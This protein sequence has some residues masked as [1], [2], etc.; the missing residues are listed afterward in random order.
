MSIDI[1][2]SNG[3]LRRLDGA[4]I[5]SLRGQLR[6]ALLAAGDAGYD[7]ARRI[8][9]AMIDK[10]PALVARCS[11]DADVMRVVRF[12]A[13]NELLLSVKGGGHN[14]AGSAVCEGG[15]M[16]D[17]S[18]MKGVRIDA[19]RRVAHA[20]SGLLWQELD[21]E[22]QAFGLATTGGVVGET[23]IAGLTIG[24]GVGWL[25][26]KHGMS[27]D[28]L[29][30]ADVVTADGRRLTA[31]RSQH[32]DLFWALRGGGGNFGVVTSFEFALHEVG[33]VLGGLVV[34]PREAAADVIRFHRDFMQ[35]APD[36]L[37]SYVGLLTTP[38]GA[39]VVAL[40]CCY[41]GDLAAGERAVAPMRSFGRPLVDDLKV[42]PYAEV[43]AMMGAG[44]PW[45]RRNY[46]KSSFL[47]TVDDVAVNTIVEHA[48]RMSPLSAIVLEYY[49]GAAA[50]VPVEA[51][52]FPHREAALNLLILGQW[53]SAADDAA[54]IG[55][56]RSLWDAMRPWSS[57]AVYM[58]TLGEGESDERVRESY[59]VNYA[60]LATIKAKYD[61]KNL[62]RLNQNVRPLAAAA[63]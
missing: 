30:S 49:G 4:A 62:F 16:I 26:R 34:H 45:G 36:E 9:N 31:D 7:Q 52:A 33:P 15:L 40:A 25:V 6:G 56:V 35:R 38:D 8:W 48:A 1:V 29:L 21:R 59:G 50:R 60:R 27:C 11:G 19:V 24:G 13:D 43:Q 37:T 58:N 54:Q 12:A 63:S 2:G 41:C 51:T 10:R 61:P 46:W 23:G 22:T 57:T 44:F 39:P 18:P 3:D 20:Q 28:N 47:R 53:E 42:R 32:D 17:L 14:V 55:W 5:D